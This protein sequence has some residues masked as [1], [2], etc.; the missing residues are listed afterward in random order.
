VEAFEFLAEFDRSTAYGLTA[1]SR[2]WRIRAAFL[3]VC[4]HSDLK[5]PHTFHSADRMRHPRTAKGGRFANRLYSQL[6][7]NS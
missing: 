7:E 6:V 4:G 2:G 3:H 1:T 5:G